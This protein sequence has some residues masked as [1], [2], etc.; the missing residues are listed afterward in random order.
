LDNVFVLLD[1]CRATAQQPTS[2]LYSG[3]V[4]E[5]RCIQPQTLDAVW[6][7]VTADQERGLHAAV[8]A[9]YEW[10]A[11]LQQA[12][13]ATLDAQEKSA[14]RVLMFA[15]CE[16]LSADAV[17]QWLAHADG[18]PEPSPAGVCNLQ[19]SVQPEHF[20]QHIAR[21]RA[22]ISQGETYQVNYTFNLHGAQYGTPV[23]LYR[24]LR[25]MQPVAFGALACL[26][27]LDA[28]TGAHAGEDRSRWVLSSSPELF[29]RHHAGALSARPMKGTASRLADSAADLQRAHWLA[30]DPKNRAENVMI[31]DLLRNDLGRISE[32]GSVRVPTLFAVETYKTVHQMTSTITSRMRAEVRFPDMLR[33]LFPCGSITGAPKLHTMDLVA[34][35][36]GQARGLYCGAI[37]WVDAPSGA[38]Q[39]CD[40][41]LSVAIRTLVLEPPLG[42][43]RPA[44]LGVGSGIVLDSVAADEFAETRAK[45]RFLTE[46]DPGFSLFETLRVARGQVRHLHWHLQRLQ[47]SAAALGFRCDMPALHLALQEQLL[48]LEP[49]QNHRLRLDLHHDGRLQWRSAALAPLAPGPALLLLCAQPLPAG[50]TALLNHKTSLRSAYDAAIQQAVS[51]QA[52]DTIFVN[53]RGEVTEG[54]RSNLLVKING[55]W[56]TPPLASGVLAGVMRARLLQRC[57]GVG[58]RVLSVQE[59]LGAQEIRVCSA[60]RGVQRAQWLRRAEGDVLR[61]C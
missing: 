8:F 58:E 41:C 27:P 40:F 21:I 49:G 12:G 28:A 5:H 55:R 29:V 18:M 54:A 42:G 3:F 37:G 51:K 32:T 7:A 17:A 19:A 56:W 24:R 61:L 23:G 13:H 35:L 50:E 20:A 15:Q 22:L 6:Q 44:T 11:K 26:P 1:D 14:L 31:V 2:R 60:L 53:A 39:A 47:A 30:N 57:P 36:E 52:F 4:R 25:A 9:D 10:G 59:V 46:M 33:A 16:R 34:D 45:A 43:R 38:S 48:A